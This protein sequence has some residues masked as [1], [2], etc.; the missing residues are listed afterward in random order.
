MTKRTRRNHSPAF[1]ARAALAAIKG[2]R[3]LAGPAQRHDVRPGQIA[4]W[5]AQLPEG[6]AGVLGS[7]PAAEE[8]VPAAD[9]KTLHATAGELTLEN[10]VSS[11]APGRAGRLSA[12]R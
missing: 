8:A 4:A 9:A 7:G 2:E 10:D 5:R 11:G 3:T 6:A 12:R 1:K